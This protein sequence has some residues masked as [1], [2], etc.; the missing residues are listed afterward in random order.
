MDWGRTTDSHIELGG[1]VGREGA[2]NALTA[3]RELAFRV[4]KEKKKK[5]EGEGEKNART[6]KT[7]R[8]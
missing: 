5:K 2:V 4:S 8:E 1:N 6:K 3:Q 7:T